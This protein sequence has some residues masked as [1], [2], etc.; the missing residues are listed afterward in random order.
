MAH[1]T[2]LLGPYTSSADAAGKA[3]LLVASSL[4]RNPPPRDRTKVVRPKIKSFSTDPHITS[5]Y[6]KEGLPVTTTLTYLGSFPAL[7]SSHAVYKL[8]NNR[9]SNSS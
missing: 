3:M 8:N 7:S 9:L 1:P 5:D 4:S 2:K 6:L